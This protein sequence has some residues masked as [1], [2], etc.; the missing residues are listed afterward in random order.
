MCED[1]ARTHPPVGPALVLAALGLAVPSYSQPAAQANPAPLADVLYP[2]M[3]KPWTSKGLTP[4]SFAF[5]RELADLVIAKNGKPEVKIV[6]ADTADWHYPRIAELLKRYLDKCTGSS[7]EI[8]TDTVPPGKHIFVGPVNEP[9]AK[10]VF[11]QSQ[12]LK[13]DGFQVVSFERGLILCGR[14]CLSPYANRPPSRLSLYTQNV[15]RGTV[16][17]VVDFLERFVGMRWY[18]WGELGECAP[19]F[20]A[21]SLRIPPVAYQDAPVFYHRRSTY[22]NLPTPYGQDAKYMPEKYRV[23]RRERVLWRSPLMRASSAH[24]CVSNHTDT[25]WHEV[26]PDRPHMFALRKDG[27][28]MMGKRGPHSSQRCYSNEEGFREHIKAI[29]AWYRDGEDLRLFGWELMAPNAKYVLWLPNDGFPGCHCDRCSALIDWDAPVGERQMELIWGYIA[30]LCAEVKR[31]WPDKTVSTLLY[32]GWNKIPTGRKLPGNLLLCKVWNS[33]IEP[34]MKEERYWQQNIGEIDLINEYSKERMLVW[35]HYPIKPYQITFEPMPFNAPH[36]LK[37]IYS[38][39]REKIGGVV[40]NGGYL[41]VAQNGQALYL[42]YKLLWNPDIDVD[43][44]LEEFCR[45]Q[46]GP[47]ADEMRQFFTLGIDRWEK[48]KWSY[49]PAGLYKHVER[50]PRQLYWKETYP[51]EVRK[52]MQALLRSALAK[53]REGSMYRVKAKYYRDAHKPFFE[54]GEFK[55]NIARA[56]FDCPKAE[57]P[58]E[59]DGDL[60]EWEG[61]RPLLMKDNVT[62]KEVDVKTEVFVAYDQDRL[63]VAGRAH[64]P[65]RAVLP[66]TRVPRDGDIYSYDSIEIY[67]CSDQEG[68]DEAGVAKIDQHHHFMVNARGEF[69]DGYK[70][71]GDRHT[72]QKVDFD[73]EYKVQP[74]GNGFQFEMALPYKAIHALVPKPGDFWYVNFYRNRPREDGSPRYHAFAPTGLSFSDTT[75]FAVMNFPKPAVLL[76]DFDGGK[77]KFG[78]WNKP[79]PT[80]VCTPEIKNGIAYLKVRYPKAETENGRVAFSIS[81]IGHALDRPIRTHYR[82]RYRGH[83]VVAIKFHLRSKDW[84][85][86]NVDY[87][88]LH[89]PEDKVDVKEWKTVVGDRVYSYVGG[90]P[91]Y[92]EYPSDI[93]TISVGLEM[94]PGADVLIELDEIR[95][96]PR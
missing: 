50:L 40:L 35:S 80:A 90:K 6:T 7:F 5:R 88:P 65:G 4:V 41:S 22:G 52:Q 48:T 76:Y 18:H 62:G 32:G 44:E 92:P 94:I 77:Q 60:A 75:R 81:G 51:P 54:L 66:P 46:F 93:N 64:E 38:E 57:D 9:T 23:A 70:S 69:F 39:N 82:F 31:R 71:T 16:F 63:Y 49:L 26:F 12:E 85:Q 2:A 3:A 17:A 1:K 59:I 72:D 29:D 45:L 11:A 24:M 20:T 91:T 73:V 13:L 83:G 58:I 84:T 27:S 19:D 30:K 68:F 86:Q 53:T 37:R 89:P 36:V 87:K 67:L 33:V 47:A 10:E 61:M 28:R 55:D 96:V 25:R 42:Y 74:L 95:V 78:V 43:A 14:D 34:F 21:K 8:V 56:V 15:S 79:S